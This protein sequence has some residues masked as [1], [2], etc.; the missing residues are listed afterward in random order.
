MRFLPLPHGTSKF[1]VSAIA[2][3]L[4]W[5]VWGMFKYPEALWAPGDLSRFHA[6]I[7]ACSDCHRPFIGITPGQCVACHD[8]THFDAKSKPAVS[9]FHRNTIREGASCTGCHYEHRGALAQITV[10]A[11]SNPHGEFVFRAT[12]THSCSDCHDFSAGSTSR[13]F[14]LDNAIVRVLMEVGNG[15]HR[16]GKMAYCLRCHSGGR[17]KIGKDNGD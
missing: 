4:A 15:A 3:L 6:D 11:V 7:A 12:R 2:L 9:E 17:L 16:Q 8:E 13:S 5:V 14:L 10:G 1:V